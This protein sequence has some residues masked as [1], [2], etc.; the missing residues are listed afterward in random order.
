[1][2]K[3]VKATLRYAATAPN[4]VQLNRIRRILKDELDAEQESIRKET[5]EVL[6]QLDA[7]R[8]HLLRRVFYFAVKLCH[9]SSLLWAT[10][11]KPA[12]SMAARTSFCRPS[13]I[14]ELI[15]SPPGA[16]KERT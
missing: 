16:R 12:C 10:I 9:S 15:Q 6:D 1:M 7:E 3:N 5:A 14:P 2:D 4:D 13:M 8:K 11:V